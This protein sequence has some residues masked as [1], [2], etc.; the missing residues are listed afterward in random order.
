MQINSRKSQKQPRRNQSLLGRLAT[1]LCIW[2][3][4]ALQK[5][6]KTYSKFEYF[7][8]F[9]KNLF[10]PTFILVTCQLRFSE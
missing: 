7:S 4:L 1:E 9:M 3:P 5:C 8:R 2:C 6:G 10:L